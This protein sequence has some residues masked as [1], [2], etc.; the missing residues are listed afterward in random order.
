MAETFSISTS[1]DPH[2]R[3]GLEL[4]NAGRH[5]DAHEE[6]EHVWRT[7]PQSDRRFVQSL[8]HAAV[9]LYQWCRGNATAAR[10]QQA[11]GTVK[12]AEYP[13]Y[14][15]GVDSARLWTDVAAALDSPGGAVSVRLHTTTDTGT[16]DA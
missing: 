6:W 12:A 1:A 8:I 16:E 14:H 3:R 11:R 9:A 5:F 10:T 2:F 13:L 4:F 15:L 7:C